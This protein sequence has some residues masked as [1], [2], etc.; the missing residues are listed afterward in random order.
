MS[1]KPKISDEI[2]KMD[3]EYE[4]LLPVEKKLIASS[5]ILGTVLIGILI[6][7]SYTFFPAGH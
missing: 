3:A 2:A 6:F 7:I 1:D 4:P 5:L